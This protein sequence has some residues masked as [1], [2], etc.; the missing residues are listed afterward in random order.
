MTTDPGG[1][2]GKFLSALL[3]NDSESKKFPQCKQEWKKGKNKTDEFGL[4]QMKEKS[5]SQKMSRK[6][7]LHKFCA[8]CLFRSLNVVAA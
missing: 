8:E 5:D 7:F 1:N 6:I 2:E 4:K 3:L